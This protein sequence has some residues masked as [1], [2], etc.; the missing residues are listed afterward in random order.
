MSSTIR[1]Y[2]WID[3]A[4]IQVDTA[5]TSL[6]SETQA[7]RRNP[8]AETLDAP[9]TPTERQHSISL[10]RVNH[11]GEVCAQALYEGQLCSVRSEVTRKMLRQ[12]RDE[13]LDHL[14]WT[15]ER[16]KELGGNT[17]YLNV[18]WYLNSFFIGLVAGSCGDAWSLGFV[19]ETEKQVS[20]HL[21]DH[22]GRL[23]KRDSKSQKIL[24]QMQVD[25]TEHGQSAKVLGAADLPFV[26]QLMMRYQAKVMTTLSHWI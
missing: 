5:L 2:S 4:L 11:T 22:L 20:Q 24:E 6:F 10:M 19:E 15:A 17:S 18:Y 1:N 13:E 3:Q 8:A 23:P 26:I 14:A 7:A 25:E 12:A 21:S 16:I 9:L